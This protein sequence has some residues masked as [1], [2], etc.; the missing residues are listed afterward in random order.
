MKRIEPIWWCNRRR[1]PV[2][3]GLGHAGRASAAPIAN[4]EPPMTKAVAATALTILSL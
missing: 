3:G 1:S 4:S 2:S